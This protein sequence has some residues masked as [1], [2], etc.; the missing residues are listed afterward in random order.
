MIAKPAID[1]LKNQIAELVREIK[2]VVDN[3]TR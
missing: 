2:L 3:H 1:N